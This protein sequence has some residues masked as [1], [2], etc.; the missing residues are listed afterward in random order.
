LSVRIFPARLALELLKTSTEA[1]MQK[2]LARLAPGERAV[3]RRWYLRVAAFYG[4]IVVFLLLLSTIGHGSSPYERASADLI[5]A[6]TR[7]ASH[8]AR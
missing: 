7:V 2:Y 4:S 1:L 8:G 5:E 6:T 3:V